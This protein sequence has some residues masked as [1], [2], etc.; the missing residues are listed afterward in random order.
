MRR[1][2]ASMDFYQDLVNKKYSD[3]VS[4]KDAR[5]KTKF[6]KQKVLVLCMEIE[7]MLR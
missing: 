3:N 7:K 6:A 5:I 2:N 4:L 1:L